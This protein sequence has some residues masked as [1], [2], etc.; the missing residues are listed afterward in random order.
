VLTTPIIRALKQQLE[1]ELHV[2]TKEKFS[3][4]TE[5]NPFVDKVYKFEQK[6]KEVIPELKA[7]N[8]DFV[9]DLQKNM[10]S[11]KLR[12]ALGNP[13]ASFPK[14]NK[15][16]WLLVNF[17]INRLPNV[18]IVDRYF[19]AV[20]Q[21]NVINDDKG[22]DF[23]IPENEELK[24]ATIHEKLPGGYIGFVIGGMHKTKMFPVEKVIEVIDKLRLPVVLLGGKEDKDTG[25]QI[26]SHTI[27]KLVIN[28][29]GKYSLNQSASLVQQSKLI[30]TNDTGLMHIAAAFKKPIISIWGNTI[31]EF[32]MYP[33]LPGY[34]KR[35]VLVQVNNLKCRPCSKI[36][37]KKCPKKHFKCMMDQDVDEIAKM[38]NKLI[39]S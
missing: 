20:K 5:N 6:I 24:P 35:S 34:E 15:E 38:A 36:G 10:R 3:V 14:L 31:P 17:K 19:E 30:L 18:H 37:F 9:V 4:I 2:L 28:T 11:I 33:Y 39:P 23:F 22:L 32:G 7:E 26:V 25:D 13:G 12:R 21:L 8:Y 29:C 1:C 27:N 16:K